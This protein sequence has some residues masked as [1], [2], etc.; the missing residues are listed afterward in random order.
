LNADSIFYASVESQ[1]V[2]THEDVYSLYILTDF[3]KNK[4]KMK[5]TL[6]NTLIWTYIKNSPYLAFAY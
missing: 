5:R 4:K 6:F 3:H 1:E 2:M